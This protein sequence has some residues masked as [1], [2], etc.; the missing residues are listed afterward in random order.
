MSEGISEASTLVAGDTAWVLMSAALVLLMVPGLAFFY[1]GLVRTKSALNTMLMSL[2]ALA[3]V[4]V[5]WVLLGYSLAFG[6][7][8]TWIGDWS[9]VGFAGVTA[10]PNATYAA[11][12][13]Q[14]LFAAFQA[15]FAGITVALFSGAVVDRMRFAAYLV[16]G[17]L[18]TTFVYDPLAHWVWASGG[19]LREL[20]ALDFAGGTVVH[21]SAGTTAVVLALVLGPRRD[22]RRVPNVPHNVPFALLGAGLLWF[23]WFGFNAGSAL[24][25]DGI[26]ANALVTT[27]AAAAAGLVTWVL[28][29]F[30]RSKRATAV[31]AATGAVV[32][33]VAI[34][35][36]AGF[37]TPLS[38][39]AMGALAVPFSFAALHYRPKTRLD[40][41][42]DV[43]ACH[44]V[45]GVVGAVLTGVFASKAVNPLGADGL[46][47]GN[48]ELLGVQ[49]LAVLA[50]VA[51]AAVAST[52]LL[53][54]LRLVMPLRV[55][56]VAE[57][58]GIDLAE[59]GEEA[60]HGGDL[61]D[62][63]GRRTSLGDAVVLPVSLLR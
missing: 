49:V 4:T 15:M 37:V 60:Y 38:A 62:L 57:V 1:G 31:G 7:G 3:V 32:G 16:F 54:G 18:W 50:T 39:L 35:P 58:E 24:A 28:I 44:G 20:G 12:L 51:F 14:L 5:Q 9:Y 40:D 63:T 33:L 21:I 34:T 27:H 48:A 26:A 2:G 29:E 45:A 61:S 56:V 55:P 30:V 52:V 13:P 10:E 53:L 19:W 46:L 22:F 25:A 43:L 6:P 41:T 17:V 8:S 11:G 23:G 36:A 42:L 59:H 47:A